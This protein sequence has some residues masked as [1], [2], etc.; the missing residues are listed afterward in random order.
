MGYQPQPITLPGS[1][2][3]WTSQKSHPIVISHKSPEGLG[4]PK[5]GKQIENT[6]CMTILP[7]ARCKSKIL[8]K[9]ITLLKSMLADML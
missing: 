5:E 7:H 2:L 6:H 8:R 3:F 9:D 4:P 1:W